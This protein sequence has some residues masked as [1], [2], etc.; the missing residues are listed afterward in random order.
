MTGKQRVLITAGASGIGE[1]LARAFD[2]E[3]ARVH[4]CDSDQQ[5]LEQML[6][7]NRGTISGTV[8]DVSDPKSVDRLFDEVGSALGGLDVLVNN[9]GRSIRRSVQLSYD[10]FHDLERTMLGGVSLL[11]EDLGRL[12]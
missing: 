6:A 2:L 1:C 11:N 10:R 5:G 3:G 7:A 12:G 4:I 9:A 8:A